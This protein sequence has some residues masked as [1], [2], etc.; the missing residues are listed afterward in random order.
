MSA[1]ASRTD[2]EPRPDFLARFLSA[3]PLLALYFAFAAFYAWQASQKVAPTIFTD[4]LELTQLARS[5]A[6]TGH[7]ARRGVPYPDTP[8][9][10][11]YVLAPVWW[12]GS[13][14]ASFAAAKEI[15]VLVMTGLNGFPLFGPAPDY[16]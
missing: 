4:E 5:I 10:L 1:P 8:S 6:E 15:L 7:A 16:G 13:A 2:G 3:V 14:M 11:A 9:L 12:L